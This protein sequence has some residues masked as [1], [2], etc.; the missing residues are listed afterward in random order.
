MKEP[1]EEADWFAE[2][3]QPH[4]SALRAYLRARFP[5]LGDVDDVVQDSYLKVLQARKVGAIASA[6]AYLFTT[7]R[8]AAL[9]LFRRPRIFDDRPVT[10]LCVERVSEEGTNIVERVAADEEAALLLDAIDALPGRCREIFI[11][12]KL[13]GVPQREIAQRLGLSEQTVQV[14]IAR[15]ARKCAVYLR[16]RG[17]IRGTGRPT[18]EGIDG[19]P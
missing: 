13:Q 19:K 18:G 11:L 3:I 15:G 12:R 8:N 17:V 1:L 4:D 16:K 14:Q 7:A 9:A 10:D 2:E 6:K 5:L